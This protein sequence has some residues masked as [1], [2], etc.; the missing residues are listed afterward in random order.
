[1]KTSEHNYFPWRVAAIFVGCTF[2]LTLARADGKNGTKSAARQ[3]AA[4]LSSGEPEIAKRTS[5]PA[6]A[7]IEQVEAAAL[8]HDVQVRI[9]S[10]GA[11]SCTSLPLADPPRLVLDCA[12]AHMQ[13]R[14]MAARADLYPVHSVRVAQHKSDVARVVID[15][16]R[17]SPYGI[18]HDGN[19]VVVI[20][21]SPNPPKAST[22]EATSEPFESAS[23]PIEGRRD[24]VARALVPTDTGNAP[25]VGNEELVSASLANLAH[26]EKS[27]QNSALPPTEQ[28]HPAAGGPSG[29]TAADASA[30][31]PDSPTENFDP[32]STD[33][34]YVI[35][36]QDVLAINVWR[37]PEFSR[38]VPV[39]PD[40]KISLPLIG[41]LHV[42]GLTPR[43]LQ[44]RL[45]K[46]LDAYIRKPK[47]TVI[48]QEMNSRKFYIMGMVEKPGAFPLASHITVL[49]ALAMSGGF[50]D[51]AKVKQIYLLRVMAD[52]SRKR[53]PFEFKAAVLGNTSYRDIEIQ[54]GDTLVVP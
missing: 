18:R 53:I 20:F 22:V 13:A 36:V 28:A 38:S 14:P 43:M 39:R 16:E 41:D 7:S 19:S 8:G 54:S 49:D 24:S 26:A 23:H 33:Q 32:S 17:S 48:V 6:L 27:S 47:V 31:E 15:L 9:V 50:R 29:P 30:T 45:T 3:V 25:L 44:D 4:N 40:G 5:A 34:D 35:G 51:F 1:M 42:S 2:V 37:D 11:L 46:E 10:N 21:F 12:A 52:G